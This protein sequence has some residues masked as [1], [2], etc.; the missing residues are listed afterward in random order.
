[1]II[2]RSDDVTAFSVTAVSVVVVV[3]VFV[4]AVSGVVDNGVSSSATVVVVVVEGDDSWRSGKMN[5]SKHVEAGDTWSLGCQLMQSN[6]RLS[7]ATI[8]YSIYT[9][10]VITFQFGKPLIHHKVALHI[11]GTKNIYTH[12]ILKL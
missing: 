11:S 2:F 12:G 4:T 6:G 9:A 3:V 1:M 5:I 7:L 8:L 10:A